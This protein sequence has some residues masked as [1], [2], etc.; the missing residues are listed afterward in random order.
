MASYSTQCTVSVEDYTTAVR[1]EDVITHAEAMVCETLGRA[2]AEPLATGG[3]P[4][5]VPS[6]GEIVL[7][8]LAHIPSVHDDRPG[9]GTPTL[10][11][12]WTPGDAVPPG[13]TEL[14]CRGRRTV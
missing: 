13:A 11:T 8:W 4:A 1:P 14:H 6:G 9:H 5:E 2:P 12:P 10:L 7:G 3:V